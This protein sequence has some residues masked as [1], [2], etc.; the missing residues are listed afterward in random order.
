MRRHF[1]LGYNYCCHAAESCIFDFSYLSTSYK[2]I[3]GNTAA[4]MLLVGRA[5]ELLILYLVSVLGNFYTF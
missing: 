5:E 3:F 1:F 2:A 4:Q